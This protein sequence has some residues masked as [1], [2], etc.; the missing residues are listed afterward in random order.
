MK[1]STLIE[2][3]IAATIA[4]ASP[5]WG[6]DII[7][8]YYSN[9][10]IE[11]NTTDVIVSTRVETNIISKELTNVAVSGYDLLKM[12]LKRYSLLNDEW[13][14]KYSKAPSEIAINAA[15]QFIDKLPPGIS[16]PKSM[17]SSNGEVG[18]YWDIE[19]IYADIA[20]EENEIVSI[21]LRQRNQNDNE[22]FIELSA[23]EITTIRLL[24]IL[25]P[26]A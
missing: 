26:L 7:P 19:N 25:S 15:I 3:G 16:L 22:I 9:Q 6:W 18:L 24:E 8:A 11:K 13:D 17:L 20:F 23:T 5:S 12:D 4:T 21:F 10:T 2:L 14:G 1:P